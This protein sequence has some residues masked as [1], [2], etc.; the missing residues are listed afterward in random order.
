[1]KPIIAP[2]NL[3][4]RG[5][6]VANLQAALLVLLDHTIFHPLDAPNY[7]TAEDLKNLKESLQVENAQPVFGGATRKL[8]QIFQIQEGLGDHLGAWWRKKQRPG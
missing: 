6:V 1:M 3:S 5:D 4:D 7:P 2:I 8:V